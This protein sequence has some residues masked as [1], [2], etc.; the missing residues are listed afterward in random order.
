MDIRIILIVLTVLLGIFIFFVW[1]YYNEAHTVKFEKDVLHSRIVKLMGEYE[2]L[3]TEKVDL[4]EEILR[5][6]S[7]IASLKNELS[8][9]GILEDR[10]AILGARVRTKDNI[11]IYDY[12]RLL[13]E[14]L[15]NQ[16]VEYMDIDISYDLLGEVYHVATAKIKVLKK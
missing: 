6:D 16:L 9:K 15:A 5:R 1:Y 14:Q 4:N 3:N 11:E 7:E 13:A 8:V 12:K 10:I 2:K